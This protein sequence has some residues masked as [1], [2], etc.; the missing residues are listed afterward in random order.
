MNDFPSGEFEQAAPVAP[1]AAKCA[2][3]QK[4]ADVFSQMRKEVGSKCSFNVGVSSVDKVNW[5]VWSVQV[6][7]LHSQVVVLV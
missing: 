5:L 2:K 4:N 3:M 7:I 6:L 1:V